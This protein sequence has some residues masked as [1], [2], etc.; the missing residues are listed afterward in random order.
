MLVISRKA[1]QAIILGDGIEILVSEV[2]GDRVKL[3][4]NAPKD[5][6]IMRKELLETRDFNTEAG[7]LPKEQA[8]DSLRH[9]LQ[10]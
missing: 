6:P 3:C 5:V 8:L 4:I 7:A 2:A 9:L 1:G 10:P